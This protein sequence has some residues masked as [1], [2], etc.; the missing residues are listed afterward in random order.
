MHSSTWRKAVAMLIVMGAGCNSPA[1]GPPS[2]PPPADPAAASKAVSAQG[3]G[4]LPK[5]APL[6][7]TKVRQ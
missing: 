5:L 4:R 3:Q 6:S 1:G 7:S 2:D